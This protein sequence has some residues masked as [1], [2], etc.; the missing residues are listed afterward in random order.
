MGRPPSQY[1]P[2][3]LSSLSTVTEFLPLSSMPSHSLMQPLSGMLLFS[4]LSLGQTVFWL[5]HFCLW[6]ENSRDTLHV[7]QGEH[8]S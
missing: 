7:Y 6:A 8:A 1:K 2:V 3:W 5:Q 4:T